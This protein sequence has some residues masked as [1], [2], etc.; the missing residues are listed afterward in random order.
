[1]KKALLKCFSLMAAFMFVFMIFATPVAASH[2]IKAY[3]LDSVKNKN[4]SYYEAKTIIVNNEKLSEEALLING[5]VYAPVRKFI[6]AIYPGATV[7]YNS[8]SRT[9][10]VKSEALTLTATDGTYVVYA[11]DRP[12]FAKTPIVILSNGRMYIPLQSLEKALGVKASA[13]GKTISVNGRVSPLIPAYKFYREDEIYWLSRIISAES[14]GEAL[15]GQIAVGNVVL[16]RMRSK[17]FPNTIWGV[18][19]DRK[20]GVQFEPIINGSI[21]DAPTYTATLAAKICLEGFTVSDDVL[22]FLEPR[23]STSGWIQKTRPYAFTI[24]NHDFYK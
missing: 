18:I 1:M 12:L 13:S 17:D 22:Y 8:S 20:Y 3:G 21:Y 2:S 14:R 9:I 23:I 5:E 11:N 15:I 7:T 6:N 19:F 4:I 24:G 16:N 10:T